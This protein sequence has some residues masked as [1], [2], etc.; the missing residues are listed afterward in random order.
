MEY[1]LLS[2]SV[3]FATVK[4]LLSRTVDKKSQHLFNF[5]MFGAAT[6]MLF[7]FA[8]I[9]GLS[10]SLESLGFSCVYGLLALGSY[11]F[12]YG[13]TRH[14]DVG[15]SSLVYYC[16]FIIATV[17]SAIAWRDELGVLRIIGIC[18]IV[19]SFILATEKKGES[20]G[21]KWFF[22]AFLA[23]ACSGGVGIVQKVYAKTDYADQ[24]QTM[25]VVAFLIITFVSL[26]LYLATERKNLL[27]KTDDNQPSKVQPKSKLEKLLP[28]LFPIIMAFALAVCNLI[29]GILA[30]ELPGVV[31]FPVVNG[32]SILLS[33]IGGILI[34]KEKASFRKVLAI[35]IGIASIILTVI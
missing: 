22:N 12:F 34:F 16:G 26:V 4:S 2:I 1:L 31:F 11:L 18:M 21:W 7:I 27:A 14:G 17:F 24:L 20:G 25:L 33:F 28:V 6:V 29:N 23:M 15:V 10:F 19:F 3:V 8:L 9:Q 32:G 5:F 30:G 35:I 13:A